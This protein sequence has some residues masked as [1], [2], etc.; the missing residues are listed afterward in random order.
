MKHPALCPWV[1]LS[2]D[3]DGLHIT[4]T[5]RNRRFRAP[6]SYEPLLRGLDGRTPPQRLAPELT[7]ETCSDLLKELKAHRLTR[8]RPACSKEGLSLSFTIPLSQ[9]GPG[10]RMAAHV[11][12][13][14]LL[15]LW[16]PGLILAVY[17]WVNCPFTLLDNH[18][19]LGSIV[20]LV[21][22]MLL[23]ELSHACACITYGGKVSACGL[24]LWCLLPCAFVE[25]DTEP[26]RH[27]LQKA[28]VFAAGVEMNLWLAAFLLMLSGCSPVLGSPCLCAAMSNLI[29]ALLNLAL[30]P[31]LDGMHILSALLGTEDLCALSL[32][33]LTDKRSRRYLRSRGLSGAAALLFCCVG[34]LMLPALPLVLIVNLTEVLL[35]VL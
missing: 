17:A 18:L 31:G 24:M 3:A 30:A 16:L 10:G 20:G 2:A 22:G 34:A 7:E 13:H 21:L 8:Q 32:E 11:L 35:W 6:A 15:K 19:W 14:V 25:L 12:N 27:P 1:E 28:Q 5:K 23:H 26:I 9:V 33:I 29:L 4:D